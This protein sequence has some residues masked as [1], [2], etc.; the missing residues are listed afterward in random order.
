M[1]DAITE[2][3]TDVAAYDAAAYD[4]APDAAPDVSADGS[5]VFNAVPVAGANDGRAHHLTRSQHAAEPLP[6]ADTHDALRGME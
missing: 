4:A 3:L 6:H 5:A 2:Y 1:C